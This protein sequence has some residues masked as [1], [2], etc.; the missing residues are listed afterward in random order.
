[1][2]HHLRDAKPFFFLDG[3]AMFS[4]HIIKTSQSRSAIQPRVHPAILR[5]NRLVCQQLITLHIYILDFFRGCQRGLRGCLSKC[6][7]IFLTHQHLPNTVPT[8]LELW[9]PWPIL[10]F[11]TTFLPLSFASPLATFTDPF[12]SSPLWSLFTS[13]DCLS[14]YN[15][16]DS[17]LAQTVSTGEHEA[18]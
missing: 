10:P 1:M 8:S 2:N 16:R 3:T 11:T 5:A 12:P 4:S 9:I 7:L 18:C 6:Q 15:Q 13:L 17:T 14:F